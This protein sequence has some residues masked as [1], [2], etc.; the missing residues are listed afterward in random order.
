MSFFQNPFCEEFR[1]NWLLGDRQHVITFAC[2]GNAGRGPEMVCCHNNEKT[3][4]LSGNDADGTA[5]KNLIINFAIDSDMFKNWT[6]LTVDISGATAAATTP[7]EVV[8][9]LNDDDSFSSW[10]TANLSPWNKEVNYN[11]IQITQNQ[12]NSRMKFFIRSGGAETVLQ[13]NAKAGVAELP[14]YFVRH[15][16]DDTYRWDY[17]DA[18]NQL[19]LL[20]P[21]ANDV[22]A[23]VI[24]NAKD[25]NGNS[26]NLDSSTVQADWQ[27]LQGRSGLFKFSKYTVADAKITAKIEYPAGAKV[28]DLAKKTEYQYTGD[29]VSEATEIPYTLTSGDLLTPGP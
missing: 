21:G 12:P 8:A 28:G 4:D 15:T 2:K 7:A 20:D 22:D 24:T 26:L 13:F 23:N 11:K 5:K 10:F 9:A 16:V 17:T 6:S 29:L 1:G 3:Y 27:L 18:Q 25:A 14:S 19:V